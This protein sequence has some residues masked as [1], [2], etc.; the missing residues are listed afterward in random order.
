MLMKEREV[1]YKLKGVTGKGPGLTLSPVL[2][3]LAPTAGEHTDEEEQ[4]S[5][6]EAEGGQVGRNG[7]G[8]RPERQGEE[9]RKKKYNR[10]ES[11]NHKVRLVDQ[12]HQA[13]VSNCPFAI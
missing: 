13:L 12:F 11:P 9:S 5:D 3:N 2:P 10:Q 1:S 7:F 6:K 8:V 4:Y